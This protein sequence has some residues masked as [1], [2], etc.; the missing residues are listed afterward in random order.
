MELLRSFSLALNTALE[1]EL[2][3]E[4]ERVGMLKTIAPQTTIMEMGREMTHIPLVLTGTVKILTEDLNG[5]EL[6]LYYLERGDTCAM[7]LQCFTG[8]KKSEILAI[9]EDHTELVMIPADYMD[10]WMGKYSSWRSF[11]LDS[12]NS[13]F[14]ELLS[15]V[16]N[17][18]F[19]DLEG[20]LKKYLKDKV[21]ISKSSHLNITHAEIARDLHSSRVVISRLMKKLENL[22][23]LTQ[24]RNEITVSEYAE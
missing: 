15:A 16:D 7:T 5:D 13:R 11:I 3:A 2:I 9:T 22:G 24:K 19:N 1:P 4:I 17:L 21:L 8:N 10:V 6:F 14:H 20:R 23:F 12:Y 18:A